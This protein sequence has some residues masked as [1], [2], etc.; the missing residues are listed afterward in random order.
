MRAVILYFFFSLL[1]VSCAAGEVQPTEKDRPMEIVFNSDQS[2]SAWRS[3]NDGVM[4]GRSSG[5]VRFD[6]SSKN[7]EGALIFQGVI[8]TNGGGFASVRLPVSPGMLD[9]KAVIKLRIKSDARAYKLTFRTNARARWRPVSFQA[10][11][12]S[13]KKGEWAEVSIPLKGLAASV[14]GR[15]VSGARFEK[16]NVREIGIILADGLDGPFKLEMS[17]LSAQ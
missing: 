11:I 6:P 15:P 4:G 1:T 10:L 17:A 7:G 9:E 16:A 2:V 8:N 12:P 13:T 14:F 3:I 5:S